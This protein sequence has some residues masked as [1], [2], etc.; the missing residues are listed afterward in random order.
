MAFVD[1]MIRGNI[2][3][4]L[5][6]QLVVNIPGSPQKSV[7]FLVLNISKIS[8]RFFSEFGMVSPRYT[9]HRSNIKPIPCWAEIFA[10]Y[11]NT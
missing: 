4:N 9:I 1:K 11:G 2:V 10:L 3:Y 5:F 8:R 6:Y 7:H